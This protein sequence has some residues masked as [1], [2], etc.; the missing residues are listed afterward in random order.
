LMDQKYKLLNSIDSPAALKGLSAC[1]LDA[2][3]GEI[4]AFLIGTISQTG[5]HLS[6]NLGVVELTLAVHK[7]FDSPEDKIIWDVGHQSYVHK[8][9]TGRR[10]AFGG[11][12]GY[13]GISGYTK[14]EESPH[15]PFGAGH[16]STSV[17]AALGMARAAEAAE[18]GSSKR[19]TVAIVGDG[20]FTGGLIYEALN[21]VRPS[22]R[23]IVILNDNGMS[24]SQN[25]GRMADYLARLRTDRRYYRVKRAV[26]KTFLHIPL[27]GKPAVKLIKAAKGALRRTLYKS[28]FFEEFG[29]DFLGPV[30]GHNIEKLEAVLNEAKS[31]GR[32]V[33]IHA[34]TS[35]GKGYTPAENDS[36]AYHSVRSFDADS[37]V[38]ETGAAG[39]S[40]ASVCGDTLTELAERD[41]RI[42]AV[43]AAMREGCGL[44][45]FSRKFPGRF[46][47]TG[48]AEAHAAL[49]CAGLAA[50]G[51]TPALCVY[52]SF[53][54]R[55]Y[56]QLLHDIALQNLHVVIC[57]GHAGFVGGDGPTHHGLFDAAFLNHI[58]NMTVYSPATHRELALTVEYAA[59]EMSSPVA[60][61]FPKGAQ[62]EGCAGLIDAR[63]G[64]RPGDF[65][66][67]GSADASAVLI[68]YGRVCAAAFGAA[69]FLKREGVKCGVL[70]L[71]KIKPINYAELFGAL[72]KSC[73]LAAFAEEGVR[74]GGVSESIRLELADA[75]PEV[76]ALLFTAGDRFAPHGAEETLFELCGLTAENMCGEILKNWGIQ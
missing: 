18:E 31:R 48:I 47:D 16:S 75:R 70:R 61:R 46:Y 74:T 62:D 13:G 76:R 64:G 9:L 2:L 12:R 45:E 17:S 24:I 73:A 53:L 32:P 65:F 27:I 28:T 19:F 69:E 7:V 51:M 67:Y 11:L 38:E 71:N 29:F 72:P 22:D 20:S 60:V 25:V 14:R 8:I 58:P 50:G 26:E 10:D 43:T 54:Q 55:A 5:G 66:Y 35:K 40:F 15:D 4:R 34:H 30:D 33:F 21:N 59:E 1:E 36:G 68:T 6:S 57:V 52:S 3:A 56:D 23:L 63:L 39:T 44:V 37:G 41:G 49:F 42:C